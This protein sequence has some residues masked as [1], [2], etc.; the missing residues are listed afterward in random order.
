MTRISYYNIIILA[1]F[2]AR[3]NLAGAFRPTATRIQKCPTVRVATT[4][5][6]ANNVSCSR[7]GLCTGQLSMKSN[8]QDEPLSVGSRIGLVA[9]PIVWIS[10]YFVA[11][12]GAG[13]P[14]GPFGLLGGLEG[15]AY[16]VVVGLLASSLRKQVSGESDDISLPEKLS[17]FTVA[18]ALFTLLSLV[19]QQGCVPNAKPILDYSDYLPVCNA[20]DTPGFF[21]L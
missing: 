6:V 2:I 7:W 15:I 14:S 9:Q 12:T 17:F 4:V 21:G 20:D 1:L 11:T 10:L 19:I 13:L 18:G 16:L 3:I 5:R 8:N